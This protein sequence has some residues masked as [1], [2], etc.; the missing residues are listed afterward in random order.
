M[1]QADSKSFRDEI[2]TVDESGKRKWIFPKKVKGK[3]ML[4]R[5][6]FGYSLLLL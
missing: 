2:A 4:G 5:Q 1:Q 3:W 6:V